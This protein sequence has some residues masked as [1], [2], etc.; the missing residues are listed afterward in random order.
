MSPSLLLAACLQAP[1]FAPAPPESQGIEAEWLTELGAV[2][3]GYVDEEKIVGAELLVIRNDHVVLQRGFGWRHREESVPME[4]GGVFCLRSMTKAVVGAAVQMLID[5][6]KL[7]AQA[8]V[9]EYLPSFDHERARA[10]TVEHLLTHTSGLPLSS[11]LGVDLTGLSGEQDVAALA[12]K[13]GPDFAP[14]TR[15]QYS[16][17]GADTLG[18][19]IEVASGE[20]LEE[21]L[22]ARLFEPLGM[23]ETTGVMRAD[24]P[25]RERVC[26]KYAGGPG[27]WTR[28]WSPKDPPLFGFLLGSQGLYGT[29]LDYARFLHLWKEQGRAGG[30]RVLS[31]R[32]VRAALEPRNASSTPSCFDGLETRYGEMMQLWIDPEAAPERRLV[33]FGHGGS[34]GTMAWVFPA[35]DLMV[36][37]FTQSRNSLT[38]LEFG[39]AVQR[40]LLDRLNGTERAEP[41]VY[42]AGELDAFTG[43]YWEEDDQDVQAVLRRGEALFVEFPG[44]LLAELAPTERRDAFRFRLSAD[45]RLEFERDESG[46]VVAVTGLA[47]GKAERMPRLAP[48]S[49]LPS[50]AV[51][52]SKRKAACDWTRLEALGPVRVRSELEMPAV[53]LSGTVVTA[54]DGLARRR[55]DGDYGS[56]RESTLVRDGRAWSWSSKTELEEL[57]GTRL[58]QAL[59]DH[60]YLPV[61]DWSRLYE[62]VEVLAR[63]VRA[64]TPALLVRATPRGGNAHTWLVGEESGLALELLALDELP[65][66]GVVGSVTRFDDW[67]EV[68]GVRLPFRSSFSFSSKILGSGTTRWLEVESVVELTDEVFETP[69]LEER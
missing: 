23:R 64:G 42:S 26:S 61:A 57:S 65:G 24:H 27:A 16:D 62:R 51:L 59:L 36:F 54:V 55:S 47:R 46:S 38:V 1:S 52:H 10:I 2:V 68:A 60:P 6:G 18:A 35:L 15:Y 11:L 63:I 4:P 14:G 5:E 43:C 41:V 9:A 58:S 28:Y 17:D 25:L 22:H 49:D 50:V 37:Y 48:A 3:L 53:G 45:H 39:S 29:A 8:P 33:A 7:A 13:R 66:M 69:A 20:A 40:C 12:G 31:E 21:F 44:K 67:R 32:A 56:A 34:D 19:L 30:E